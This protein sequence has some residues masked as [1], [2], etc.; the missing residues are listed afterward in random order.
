MQIKRIKSLSQLLTESFIQLDWGLIMGNRTIHTLRSKGFQIERN[1]RPFTG[2]EQYPMITFKFKWYFLK[3]E[4]KYIQSA[5]KAND[6]DVCIE[7]A[8]FPNSEIYKRVNISGLSERTVRITND[9]INTEW[10]MELVDW[11]GSNF[12]S[13]ESALADV[14]VLFRDDVTEDDLNDEEF[15]TNTILGATIQDL[16]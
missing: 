5:A 7:Y 3:G 10:M 2:H 13:M 8:I 6:D 16:W 9:N 15:R 14:G 12:H 4:Q 11:V 1:M